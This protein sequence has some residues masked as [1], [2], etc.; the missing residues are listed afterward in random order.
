M[1]RGERRGVAAIGLALMLAVGGAACGGGG[2]G[3][4]DR[5]VPGSLRQ[6][7]SAAEDTIDLILAGRR[8]QAVRSAGKLDRLAHGDLEKDLAGTASKEELGDFQARA[9]ELSRLA[10]DGEP[11]AVALAA[12]RAFELVARFFGRYQTD[13]P[14]RVMLLDYLDFEAK[15]RALAHEL[16]PVR[17]TV[18]QLSTTW[19]ELA[20]MLPSGKKAATA[21]T[22][23]EAHVAAMK[24]LVAAGTDFDGMAKEAQH[25]LDLVD[26]IEAVY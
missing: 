7:E 1:A 2:G 23:F 19:G 18:G 25:G 4:G 22:E 15:L 8:D 20:P 21:R 11:V 10:P 6:A 9:A 12:N 26:E 3:E 24:T 14:G 17:A 13:V 16:D 5:S